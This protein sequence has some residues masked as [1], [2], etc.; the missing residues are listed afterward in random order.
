MPLTLERKVELLWDKLAVSDLMLAFGRGLDTADWELYAS[1]FADSFIVDFEQLTS[2]PPARTTPREWSAFAAAALSPLLVHHQYSNQAISIQGDV[3]T[4]VIYMVA[5]HRDPLS[6]DWNTQYGW[7][8]NTFARCDGPFG[9]HITALKHTFRWISGKPD[10]I[11]FS[12][13]DTRAALS[14]VFGAVDRTQE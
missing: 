10:I 12:H 3:A 6:D 14:A 9:W 11:D 1:C 4:G 13:P 2:L 7:Y 5:R 8:E